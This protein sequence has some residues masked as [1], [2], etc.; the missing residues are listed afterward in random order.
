MKLIIAGSR[1]LTDPSVVDRAFSASGL[2]LV[3]VEEV[4]CGGA[5]GVDALGEDGAS[6]HDI[7]VQHFYPDW[8]SYGR[9]AGP[10]RKETPKAGGKTVN[11]RPLKGKMRSSRIFGYQL[12]RVSIP[13]L[14]ENTKK[15]VKPMTPSRSLSNME[16]YLSSSIEAPK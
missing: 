2:A 16:S 7:P 8:S 13:K 1:H 15:S 10:Q 4:V 12:L 14:S 6:R 11:D 3:D 5:Q 9:A